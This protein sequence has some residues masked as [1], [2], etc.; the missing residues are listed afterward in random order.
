[1]VKYSKR[2]NYRSLLAF[3]IVTFVLKLAIKLKDSINCKSSV[4]IPE[5]TQFYLLR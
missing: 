2:L 5:S 4:Q 3:P 1:M